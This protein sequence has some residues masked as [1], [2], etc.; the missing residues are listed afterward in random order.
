MS[1]LSIWRKLLRRFETFNKVRLQITEKIQVIE[2]EGIDISIPLQFNGPQ[3]NAYGV[4]PARSK[5]YRAGDLVGDTRQGGSVNFEEYTFTPHCNGTHTECVGHITDER[6]SVRD[7]L[8][9]VF[10]PAVLVSVEPEQSSG[11]LV[12]SRR[13]LSNAV[14]ALTYVR[15]T[16][17][18]ALI[19]RTLPNDD[20][21]LTREYGDYI[22]PYFTA[23]AME[24]IVECGFKHLLVDMPSIDR[25][26]DD[27]KLVNH[28][29]FWNVEPGSHEVKADSRINSTIT[30]LIYVANEIEDGEYLLN[31]QIAPFSTDASP[32]RPVLFK[33]F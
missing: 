21:K 17:T 33:I 2:D 10:I 22:P 1:A 15:A 31:L 12:L 32:S 25:I 13:E 19:V 8:R 7:C 27:G 16:D 9:D 11:D 28:R 18:S 3:P 29:L 26:F 23:D 6:I 4:E 20:G 5:P 14:G 30:E 24:F